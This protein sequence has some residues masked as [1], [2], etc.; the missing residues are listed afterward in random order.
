MEFEDW[1]ET[2]SLEQYLALRKPSPLLLRDDLWE[3]EGTVW[4]EGSAGKV[5]TPASPAPDAGA[6]PKQG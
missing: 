5:A 1:L 6:P 4:L 3:G 2:L